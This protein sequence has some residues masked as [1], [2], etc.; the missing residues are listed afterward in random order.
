SVKSLQDFYSW[1]DLGVQGLYIPSPTIPKI[2]TLTVTGSFT[3]YT[4]SPLGGK[5]SPG[6]TNGMDYQLAQDF[7]MTHGAHQISYGAD[8][9]HANVNYLSGTNAMGVYSFKATNTGLAMGDFFTGQASSWT[10]GQLV[11]WY[12]RQHYVALYA[13]D[14]WKL[15]RRL[16]LI[17][18][19]RW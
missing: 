17:G 8:Y 11:T 13:Q 16:T 2:S 9:I 3:L 15:S 6:A 1:A 19:V 7:N 4:G 18:G 10:Q 14:T 12:P 5:A